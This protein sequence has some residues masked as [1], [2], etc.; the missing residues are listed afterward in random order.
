MTS[1]L[2]SFLRERVW[3]RRGVAGTLAWVALRPLA[4]LFG[5]GVRL[6][7]GAYRLGVL[8]TAHATVPVVSVGNLVVGGAGKTP[9]TLWLA[10]ALQGRGWRP[11]IVLRGYGGA[12]RGPTVVADGG[13]VQATVA[14]VGDE[15]VMLGK[16][17]S[18]V[19]AVS[20]R[21][22]EGAA[23]AAARGCD[24]VVLDDGFQHRAL[25]RDC[26]LVLLSDQRPFLL[27]AGPYREPL[28][29]LRR[30]HAVVQ[31]VKSA[32][33]APSPWR[34]APRIGP[35][36]ATCD[37]R[38]AT[39]APWAPV[40]TF[41]ARFTATALVASLQGR[42]TEQ[43]VGLLAGRRVATV[44]G[45]ADPQPFHDMVRQWEAQVVEIIALDDHHAYTVE[46]WRDIAYRTRDVDLVLTTEKDLVKLEAFP[47]AVG[48][49]LALR[50]APEVERGE[51]LVDLICT[52]IA[53]A[54]KGGNHGDQPG[55]A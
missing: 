3:P 4:T 46:D 41:T 20:R 15:A 13:A 1:R 17:F 40:P 18:G 38:R 16:R 28:S 21:R 22:A 55:V 34:S 25:W 48:K 5:V 44:S 31:V 2:T 45:I 26:D 43:P 50:I 14:Q 8:R 39:S 54:R 12:A 32:N 47:F 19:V 23:A 30:A 35:L 24:V 37:E 27:P 6:R 53:E 51:A 9:M 49:L 52:R 33:G 7:L 42:W 10:Q 11:A 29:A 36:G